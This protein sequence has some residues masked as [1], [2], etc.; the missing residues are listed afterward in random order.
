MVIGCPTAADSGSR[1]ISSAIG[2]GWATAVLQ[3]A[4]GAYF[5]LFAPRM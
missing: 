4:D 1:T 3:S 5:S 2:S